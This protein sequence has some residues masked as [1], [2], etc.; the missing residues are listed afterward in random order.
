ME[1]AYR[2]VLIKPIDFNQTIFGIMAWDV[3]DDH[4][5]NK[6]FVYDVSVLFYQ[7]P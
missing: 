7:L 5:C 1:E 3:V 4:C 2:H 6:E